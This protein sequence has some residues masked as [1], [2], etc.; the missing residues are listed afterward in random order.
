MPSKAKR[1]AGRS[2]TSRG[3]QDVQNA[4]PPGNRVADGAVVASSAGTMEQVAGE[5]SQTRLVAFGDPNGL[6]ENQ[7]LC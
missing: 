7:V 1:A 5:G 2:A 3:S 4:A 6:A